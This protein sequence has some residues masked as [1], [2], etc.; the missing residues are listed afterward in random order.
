MFSLIKT[1]FY[2]VNMQFGSSIHMN[3][4][5]GVMLYMGLIGFMTFDV[6]ANSRL[7]CT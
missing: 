3:L 4:L 2:N 7:Y 6:H 5:I 1:I